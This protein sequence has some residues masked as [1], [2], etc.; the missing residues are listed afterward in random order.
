MHD[1]IAVS[2][3]NVERYSESSNVY[4]SLG[5]AYARDGQRELAMQNYQKSIELNPK[6]QNAIDRPKTLKKTK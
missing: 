4:D 6:I 3:C 5:E 1:A 2:R